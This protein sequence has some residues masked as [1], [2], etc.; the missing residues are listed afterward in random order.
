MISQKH[1]S[2]HNSPHQY[3]FII[4]MPRQAYYFQIAIADTL[5]SPPGQ[6]AISFLPLWTSWSTSAAAVGACRWM[7]HE[8]ISLVF[9]FVWLLAT[10]AAWLSWLVALGTFLPVGRTR[11]C[12]PNFCC[13]DTDYIDWDGITWP[14]AGSPALLRN[15]SGPCTKKMSM[16]LNL[17]SITGTWR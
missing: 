12:S 2:S 10:R 13:R 17:C 6:L 5:I 4:S 7:D 15:S 3:F 16:S 8:W 14:V 11:E 1:L 9:G